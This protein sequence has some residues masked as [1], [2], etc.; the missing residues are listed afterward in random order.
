VQDVKRFDKTKQKIIK[1]NGYKGV[2]KM[3]EKIWYT[4]DE[5]KFKLGK[6]IE[7]DLNKFKNQFKLK[8]KIENFLVTNPFVVVKVIDN[9]AIIGKDKFLI[10]ENYNNLSDGDVIILFKNKP[11]KVEIKNDET[12]SKIED[13]YE[14]RNIKN[15][16]PLKFY[17]FYINK[18]SNINVINDDMII[19]FIEDFKKKIKEEEIE[20]INKEKNEIKEFENNGIYKL[21]DGVNVMII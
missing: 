16:K 14:Y 11:I 20:K 3:E 5:V 6:D 8:E 15:I 12:L 19:K 4:L 7:I 9:F 10:I 17:N 13:F 1:R 2:V 18:I 21:D